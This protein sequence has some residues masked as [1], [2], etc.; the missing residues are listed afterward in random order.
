MGHA[1]GQRRIRR[2]LDRHPQVRLGGRAVVV[3]AD[4]NDLGAAI[5]RL[6]EEMRVGNLR[7]ERIAR[8]EQDQVGIEIL[9]CRALEVD[10]AEGLEGATVTVADL[11]VLV[12]HHRLADTGDAREGR[13]VL[14]QVVGRADI[15]NDPIGA[16]LGGHIQ[17]GIG[18][19]G[20][21]GIPGDALPFVLTA[22][23]HPLQRMRHPRRVVHPLRVA[24]ALLAAARVVVGQLVVDLLVFRR[25]LL[26]EDQAILH[27]HVPGT[28]GLIPAV[29]D[30]RATH[31][32]V[33]G[34]L[35][36]IHVLPA[37]VGRQGLAQQRLERGIA[38]GRKAGG[39]EAGRRAGGDLE[40]VPAIEIGA[41]VC[42]LPFISRRP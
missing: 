3:R 28:V 4:R 36:A 41:H 12:D 11:A 17:P 22:R 1:H 23:A 19:I 30:V 6:G 9:V 15:P 32:L 18:D 5:F 20:Q 2:R 8:P 40:K 7:V 21:G 38:R 42:V 14:G 29:H 10:L 24:T 13:R 31:H 34:P 25:L 27:I 35:L 16:L 37:A 26:A 33:P 39:S